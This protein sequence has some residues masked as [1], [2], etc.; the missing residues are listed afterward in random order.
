MPREKLIDLP[1]SYFFWMGCQTSRVVR[2]PW[3]GR[4]SLQSIRDAPINRPATRRLTTTLRCNP[5]NLQPANELRA[6]SSSGGRAESLGVWNP[7]ATIRNRPTC[8]GSIA[9][10]GSDTS[11]GSIRAVRRLPRLLPLGRCGVEIISVRYVIRTR[12]H[13]YD[14]QAAVPEPCRPSGLRG[15]ASVAAYLG[16]V[17]LRVPG[18]AIPEQLGGDGGSLPRQ[19]RVNATRTHA[20]SSTDQVLRLNR[21]EAPARLLASGGLAPNHWF[22]T[23]VDHL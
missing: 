18:H 20:E 2:H 16:I 14:S 13:F 19:D 21:H 8:S 7:R 17:R 9:S 11:L 12:R 4:P 23:P 10:S 22:S 1:P 15:F 3:T 6:Y 5:P